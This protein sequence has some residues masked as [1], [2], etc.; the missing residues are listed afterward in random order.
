IRYFHVT[1]VQTCALPISSTATASNQRFAGDSDRRDGSWPRTP[2]QISSTTPEDSMRYQET[3]AASMPC[4][5]CLS[6]I[7]STPQSSVV[8]NANR[9]PYNQRPDVTCMGISRFEEE[10]QRPL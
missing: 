3:V 8:V 10:R 4:S 5:T 2:S 6:M 1:G 9:N 7:G